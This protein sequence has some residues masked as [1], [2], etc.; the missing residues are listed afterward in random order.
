MY[1]YVYKVALFRTFYYEDRSQRGR[2]LLVTDWVM[3]KFSRAVNDSAADPS[4]SVRSPDACVIQSWRLVVE[5]ILVRKDIARFSGRITNQDSRV[6]EYDHAIGKGYFKLFQ[7][8][9]VA[10]DCA[11]KD[12]WCLTMRWQTSYIKN[13]PWGGGEGM[14]DRLGV[15][16]GIYTPLYKNR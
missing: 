7:K 15:G 8:Q 16:I 11:Q 13:C 6:M 4:C 1:V 2:S 9:F 3:Q 14:R 10:W 12:K 5:I